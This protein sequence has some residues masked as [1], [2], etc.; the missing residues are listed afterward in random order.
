MRSHV[1][2][3][4]G[5]ALLSRGGPSGPTPTGRSEDRPAGRK[6]GPTGFTDRNV[7]PVALLL[8]LLLAG[9]GGEQAVEEWAVTKSYESDGVVLTLKVDRDQISIADS[10][11]VVLEALVPEGTDLQFPAREP[12]LGEFTQTGVKTEVPQLLADNKV[13]VRHSIALEP[14]LPGDYEIPA[15]TVKVGEEGEIATDPVPVAVLSVLPEG[16]GEDVDIKEIAPPVSLP[17]ISPWIWVAIVLGVLGVAGGL[18]YF[19]WRNRKQAEALEVL[20]Q[21]HE[22]ALRALRELMEEGLIEKG[23]QKLF[24]LKVSGI[25]RHYIEGRFGMHAPEST[26][27]EFLRDLGKDPRLSGDQK[28]LLQE[29][30]MH[31]DIVKFAEYQPRREEIDETINT[32][33]QFVAE[34]K[35]VETQSVPAKGDGS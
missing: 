33:A 19:W 14:F 16:A 3:F 8:L 34:T 31:C 23:E 25:L 10:V 26:T 21:P 4:C 29:F 1:Q 12:K 30:L 13:L 9:C 6:A 24:Y 32:C 5:A 2:Q 15:L 7:W 22:V 35:P 28:D 17:G 11:E 18:Y 27:E 20:P